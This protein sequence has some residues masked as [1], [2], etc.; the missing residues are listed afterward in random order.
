MDFRALTQYTGWKSPKVFMR[1]YFKNIDSL[2]FYA[3]AA[4]KVVVPSQEDSDPEEL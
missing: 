2:K 4:G 3:V 1:H